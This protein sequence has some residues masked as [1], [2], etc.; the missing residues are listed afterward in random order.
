M[1]NLSLSAN[2]VTYLGSVMHFSI[3][4][5]ANHLTNFMGTSYILCLLM[6]FLADTY[7]GRFKTVLI[8]ACIELM[9]YTYS[10]SLL[11]SQL[12]FLSFLKVY[13]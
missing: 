4:D 1:A 3:A 12:L 2:G 13:H 6:A 5:S 9:V 11:Q 10:P 7:V 8:A